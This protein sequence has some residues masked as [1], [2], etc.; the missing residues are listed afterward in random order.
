MDFHVSYRDIKK[1]IGLLSL[2]PLAAERLFREDRG[3]CP[4]SGCMEIEANKS[5][6]SSTT[7]LGSATPVY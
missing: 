4:S 3:R 1:G 7:G 2:E 6:I 5:P